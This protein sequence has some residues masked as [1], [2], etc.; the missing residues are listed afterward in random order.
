MRAEAWFAWH[1]FSLPASDLRE[2]FWIKSL[3][4]AQR[5]M[6]TTAASKIA[7]LLKAPYQIKTPMLHTVACCCKDG[8]LS[9]HLLLYWFCEKVV[10]EKTPTRLLACTG[11]SLSFYREMISDQPAKVEKWLSIVRRSQVSCNKKLSNLNSLCI[12]WRV[13]QTLWNHLHY[14]LRGTVSV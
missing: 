11:T 12:M 3:S 5:R 10:D 4:S 8:I 6:R 9:W 2:S 14:H 13:H 7:T 1:V